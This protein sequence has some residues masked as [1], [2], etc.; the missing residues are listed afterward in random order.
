MC[1]SKLFAKDVELLEGEE[2]LEGRTQTK[3][4]LKM[5]RWGG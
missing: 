5:K 2:N 3:Q 1:M 4:N